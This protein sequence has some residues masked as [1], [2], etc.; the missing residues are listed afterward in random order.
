M[1]VSPG[2]RAR[3][4]FPRRAGHGRAGARRKPQGRRRRPHP[5]KTRRVAT[6]ARYYAAA[7][8]SA[9]SISAIS[10]IIRPRQ[11]DARYSILSLYAYGKLTVPANPFTSQTTWRHCP[12]KTECCRR[13]VWTGVLLSLA[14]FRRGGGPG[15][16]CSSPRIS[17]M[18]TQIGPGVDK[19]QGHLRRPRPRPSRD[20]N[21]HRLWS[22]S[23]SGQPVDDLIDHPSGRHPDHPDR[24]S[25]AGPSSTAIT[26]VSS[27][28]WRRCACSASMRAA[29]SRPIRSVSARR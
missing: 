7:R 22:N 2:R 13:M 4:G 1:P 11:I 15:R 8:R 12:E 24:A 17:P 16:R 23:L 19:L 28:T 9:S 27:S 26:R 20:R 21:P 25:G 18:A 14:S 29:R 6:L 10:S 3:P 5:D